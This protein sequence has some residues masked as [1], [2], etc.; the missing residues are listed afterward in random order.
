MDPNACLKR[1]R[2]A[3]TDG[4]YDKAREMIRA[5]SWWLF[6]RG[7]FLPSGWSSDANRLVGAMRADYRISSELA[8][9]GTVR[10]S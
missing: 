7:G 10:L 3:L 6:A 1:F 8:T 4:E 9:T 5:M 2:N